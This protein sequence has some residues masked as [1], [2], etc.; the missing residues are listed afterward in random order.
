MMEVVNIYLRAGS[1]PILTLL[2]CSKAFDLCRFSDIFSGLLDRG[3]PPI[4]V[5]VLTFVYEQQHAW[6]R[7]GDSKS[8]LFNILNGTTQGSV[9]SAAVF[10]VYMEPL[11]KQLRALGLGCH[12]AGLFM[13]VLGYCDDLALLAPSRD[14]M[15]AMLQVCEG[16]AARVGLVFSTD[17]VPAKSKSKCILM[18]GK[19]TGLTKPVPLVLNGK[20]LPWVASATHLGYEVNETGTMEMDARVKRAKFIA[21]SVEVRESFSFASPVEVLRATKVYCSA[22]YGSMLWSMEIQWGDG[23]DDV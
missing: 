21:D 19:R 22:M 11:L 8:D 7:W 1:H 23:R 13:G 12:V 15:Q 5:R 18:C 10:T 2:D 16:F 17:P 14:A 6:V 9:L 20:S 3:L 4:I